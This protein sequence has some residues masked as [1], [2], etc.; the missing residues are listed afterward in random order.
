[1]K[2]VVDFRIDGIVSVI[3]EAT[4]PIIATDKA[5]EILKNKINNNEFVPSISSFVQEDTRRVAE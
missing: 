5:E 3:V 1:M 4:D 2:Y